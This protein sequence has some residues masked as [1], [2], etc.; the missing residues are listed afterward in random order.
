MTSICMT[1]VGY[2]HKAII[3]AK[4][5]FEKH[6]AESNVITHTP[7]TSL[8]PALMLESIPIP[9]S[10]LLVIQMS[11]EDQVTKSMLELPAAMTNQ[12]HWR[13]TVGF[14]VGIGPLVNE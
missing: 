2:E 1:G 10:D 5:G 14:I 13:R 4:E 9:R 3:S 6:S 8:H 11:D 12:E 7:M